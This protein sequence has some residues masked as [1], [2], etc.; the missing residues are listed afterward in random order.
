MPPP[1]SEVSWNNNFIERD[2]KR[3]VE[4]EREREGREI[5]REGKKET[6]VLGL[7]RVKSY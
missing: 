1:P 5:D 3:D 7:I 6:K 2:G 4:R